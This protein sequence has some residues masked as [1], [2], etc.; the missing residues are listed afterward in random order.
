M[1]ETLVTL[2]E[3]MLYTKSWTYIFMGVALAVYVGYWIFLT[4]RD[5]KIRKY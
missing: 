4:G 3:F 2:H 5:E 1:H